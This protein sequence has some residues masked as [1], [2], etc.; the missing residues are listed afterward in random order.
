M[1]CTTNVL[2]FVAHVVFDISNYVISLFTWDILFPPV[3]FPH[4]DI[5]QCHII[6]S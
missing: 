6:K 3:A 4:N 2:T 1:V 5:K